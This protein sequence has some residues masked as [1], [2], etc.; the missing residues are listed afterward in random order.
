MLLYLIK[1][2]IL[3]VLSLGIYKL[4]LENRKNHH[5]KR[6]YLLATLLL[7]LI[8][9]LIKIQSNSELTL[10]NTKLQAL[11]EVI[12]APSSNP[13]NTS[14]TW[15]TV[16]LMVYGIVA[17]YFLTRLIKSVYAFR[18]LEQ[19][20]TIVY[21]KGQK[22]VLLPT[23]DFAFTFGQTIYLPLHIPIDWSNK[24]ILHEYNHVQ[25]KH[26]LDIL[27][28]EFIK[29][30]FWFH[31]AIYYYKENM[32]LNHEFLADDTL[33]T[34]QTEVQDYLQLLL[35]QNYTQN[36]LKLSS[37][38]NFNLTKKRFIMI[39]KKNTP[40]QNALAVGSA[41]LLLSV[42]GTYTVFA[43]DKKYNRIESQ[44]ASEN[45]KDKVFIQVQQHA[46]YPGGMSEFN[47][48]F[49]QNFETPDFPEASARVI[50]T[51][52][53]EK[54]G[55]LN[56]IKVLKDPGYGMAEAA[57]SALS[58]T[59]NWKPAIHN[60]EPVRSQFTLPIAIQVSQEEKKS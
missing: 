57:L 47:K 52:I 20:G 60:G 48:E 4:G 10:A 33:N 53:V 50:I 27:L 49:I 23:N 6:Y 2:T 43:Q 22:F 7:A 29:A 34:T 31:P 37:S 40:W 5:F 19:K 14:I 13:E 9:P 39:T 38:F 16:T 35:H 1:T 58:K 24:I 28:I 45:D 42:V 26:T 36:E 18:K 41:I 3:L 25:Q 32:V 12:I 8:L 11:N 51:F 59:K 54:D 21:N 15:A 30:F 17:L 44:P 46:E 56:E 55:S